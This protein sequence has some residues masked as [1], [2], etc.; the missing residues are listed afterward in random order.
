MAKD[1]KRTRWIHTFFVN[2]EKEVEEKQETQ[3][4]EGNDITVLKKVKKEVPHK[5]YLKRPTRKLIES[6]DLFYSVK[7]SEGIK[8]GLL[9]RTLLARRYDDDGGLF[10]EIDQ[11]QYF[12]VYDELVKKENEY[13]QLTLNLADKDTKETRAESGKILLEITDLRRTMAQYEEIQQNIFNNTAENRARNQTIM[14]WVLN[15]SF[16]DPNGEGDPVPV[17]PGK[18]YDSRLAVYDEMEEEF[19]E[20]KEEIIKKLAFFVSFWYT[21]RISDPEDFKIAEELYKT[22]EGDLDPDSEENVVEIEKKVREMHKEK[23]EEE[24][25]KRVEEL[26][27]EKKVQ[28]VKAAVEDSEKQLSEAKAEEKAKPK[29]KKTRKKSPNK[30]PEDSSE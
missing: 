22:N 25:E 16:K 17:F 8:A 21:G 12:E 6:A 23:I 19:D 3:D 4:E 11:K 18:D 29:A 7:L 15:L 2:E 20:T 24:T 10:S 9:T 28:K 14:W 13:H 5:F 27:H 1:K 30:K 26:K